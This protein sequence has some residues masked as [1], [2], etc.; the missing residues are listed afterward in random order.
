MGRYQLSLIMQHLRFKY[1]RNIVDLVEC[2]GKRI[3]GLAS[4]DNVSNMH[5]A[6]RYIR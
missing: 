4:S 6:A 3:S 5:A 1:R 2:P